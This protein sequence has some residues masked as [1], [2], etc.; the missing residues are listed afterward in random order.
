MIV[1]VD[2]RGELDVDGSISPSDRWGRRKMGP[3]VGE[4]LVGDAW[5]A[6]SSCTQGES[7]RKPMQSEWKKGPVIHGGAKP[8]RC[9]AH[10]QVETGH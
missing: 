2:F 4:I 3:R 5:Q 10:A 6:E 7:R 8:M 9:A 1:C